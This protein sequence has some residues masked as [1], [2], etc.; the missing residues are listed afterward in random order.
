MNHTRL[1]LGKKIGIALNY[2]RFA[3]HIVA[4]LRSKEKRSIEMD[5]ARSLSFWGYSLSP[6][7]AFVYMLWYDHYFRAVF[8]SRIGRKWFWLQWLAK[9]PETF[10]IASDCAIG[11]GCVC[12]HPF[13]TIV[14]AERIGTNFTIRN[15]VTIGNNDAQ[16]GTVS[17]PIIGDNVTINV[18]S[19]VVGNISIGNNVTIGAGCI[20]MKSVPDNCVVVGNPAYIVRQNGEKVKIKL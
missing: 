18:N 7:S 15:N 5:V 19:V 8:Y 11:G 10:V 9:K 13:A 1:P 2:L 12:F 20:L 14:N 16:I 3:P 4:Y 17:R 6:M